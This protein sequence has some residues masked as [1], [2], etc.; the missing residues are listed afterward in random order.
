MTPQMYFVFA[1]M[2]LFV[3]LSIS[4]K[5]KTQELRD[6]GMLPLEGAETMED[7]KRLMEAGHKIEAIKIYRILHNVGLKEAKEKVEAL[8]KNSNWGTMK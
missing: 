3:F 1:V 6:A 4:A 2:I 7:V 5:R 8:A